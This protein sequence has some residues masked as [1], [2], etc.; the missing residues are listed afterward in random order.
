MISKTIKNNTKA[1]VW[2]WLPGKK[3]PIVCGRIT[4]QNATHVFT[5]GRSYLE[6]SEAVPLSPFELPLISGEQWP[7]RLN[8]IH[9][10]LRDASPDAWGRRL[11]E[12]QFPFLQADELDFMLLSGSNRIGALDFQSSDKNYFYREINHIQLDDFLQV[13]DRIEKNQPLPL[14]LEPLLLR[15]TSVG[16]ARPKALIQDDH[17]G[18]IAKFSLS[19]DTY[20]I[21]KSEYLGMRLAK[22]IGLDVAD[23][24]LRS[25]L[26]KQI[27]LIK[28]FDR[29]QSNDGITRIQMLSG[30][31][32]LDLNEM[33][34]RYARYI[35]LA[36]I[37]RQRFKNPKRD[38]LELYQRLIF[39]VLIGNTDDHARN[40]SAFWDGEKLQLTPAYDLCPQS[41]VGET[42]SQAMRIDG[43][44]GNFSTVNNVLSISEAFQISKTQAHE[45]IEKMISNINKNWNLVCEEAKLST[46]EQ[47]RFWGK[48]IFN[49]FCFRTWK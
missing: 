35:D 16:G 5:Y 43:V 23:V 21:I 26:G 30:L 6:N 47:E 17:V 48:M 19:T 22:L 13:A 32:L 39:N 34:A 2:V 41:R 33:E 7:T 31:S 8:T 4:K 11:L 38:L 46:H 42:A 15:G 24:Q 44:E 18:S 29:I 1:Y 37:I 45:L 10:C 9:S 20:D 28:R 14:E 49:P 36:D 12:Y 3:D 27:L 25:V 40:H